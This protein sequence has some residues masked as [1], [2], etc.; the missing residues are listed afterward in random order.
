MADPISSAAISP[1]LLQPTPQITAADM[2]KRGQIRQTAEKFETQFLSI[3]LQQMF[4]GVDDSA[5]PFS[6]GQGASMFRSFLTDAMAR[7]MTQAGGVGI[8]DSVSREMLK[9]QGMN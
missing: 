3:M 2:A 5:G 6:G 9:L 4:K 7:N 1:S 8:A